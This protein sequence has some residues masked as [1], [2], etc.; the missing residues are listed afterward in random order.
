MLPLQG[1]DWSAHTVEMDFVTGW[2]FTINTPNQWPMHVQVW[3]S[4][5]E[6]PPLFQLSLF[7]PTHGLFLWVYSACFTGVQGNK[8]HLFVYIKTKSKQFCITRP[9]Y[10]WCWI[11]FMSWDMAYFKGNHSF[12]RQARAGQRQGKNIGPFHKFF[13]FSS[14]EISGIS[15]VALHVPTPQKN[16]HDHS[17]NKIRGGRG[18]I[19]PRSGISIFWLWQVP[20]TQ[21]RQRKKNPEGFPIAPTFCRE[22]V[23]ERGRKGRNSQGWT[24]WM[25]IT[26]W[27]TPRAS[28]W[29]LAWGWPTWHVC[30]W[31]KRW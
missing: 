10:L 9:E 4:P 23:D 18:V 11:T 25:K 31:G 2:L 15:S 22:E 24:S 6:L 3:V 12:K 8:G 7:K 19:G 13:Y 1:H 20:E 29:A 26:L 5:A 27:E 21:V 17:G 30:A 14:P 16:H 28:G